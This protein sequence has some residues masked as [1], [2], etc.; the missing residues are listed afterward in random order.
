MGEKLS[1]L[2]LEI[3]DHTNV[4]ERGINSEVVTNIYVRDNKT[5]VDLPTIDK[6]RTQLRAVMQGT[7]A[8]MQSGS[9]EDIRKMQR[10]AS[11]NSLK[12]SMSSNNLAVLANNQALPKD[13]QKCIASYQE[14]KSIIE[15]RERQV[16]DEMKSCI[17]QDGAVVKVEEWNPWD[18]TAALMALAGN[19]GEDVSR[20]YYLN[21]FDEIDADGGGTVDE[22]ELYDALKK[23]GVNITREGLSDMIAMVDENADGEVDRKEWSDVVDFFLEQ[24]NAEETLVQGFKS[25]GRLAQGDAT[26]K[27]YIE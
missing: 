1:E 11:S 18:W 7:N 8:M 5:S 10:V 16:R 13:V 14:E 27:F 22:D 6:Q 25:F 26:K 23:A 4:Q 15:K 2:G 12:E 19:K 20:E 17:E 24:Y 21:L 9:S 3:L